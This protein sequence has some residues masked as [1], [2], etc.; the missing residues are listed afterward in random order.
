M[1]DEK[2]YPEQL[3]ALS[4]KRRVAKYLQGA[5]RCLD[6]DDFNSV[7]TYLNNIDRYVE[8]ARIA[9]MRW[10]LREF[11]HAGY[12]LAKCWV[13]SESRQ[14]PSYLPDFEEFLCNFAALMETPEDGKD[15]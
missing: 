10:K 9:T 4:K 14:Y 7:E 5:L 15:E 11:L 3:D 2:E 8:A 13:D 12:E 6:N 1:M